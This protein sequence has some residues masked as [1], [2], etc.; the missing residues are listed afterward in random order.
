MT[1]DDEDRMLSDKLHAEVAHLVMSTE[2][3]RR[4]YNFYPL[5]V[6]TGFFAAG[7]AFMKVMLSF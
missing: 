4:E 6:A 2:K 7:A 1:R 3:M 5:I